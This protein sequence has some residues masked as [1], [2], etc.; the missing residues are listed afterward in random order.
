MDAQQQFP[1]TAIHPIVYSPFRL[2]FK[3][4]SYYLGADNGKGH[5]IHSPF[6]YAF[7]TK[8]LNDRTAYPCYREIEQQRNELRKNNN[9]LDVEDLGAGSTKMK[10][11]QRSIGDIARHSLKPPKYAQLLYRIARHYR[12]DCILELGTSLGITTAYLARGN[13]EATVITCEGASAVAEQAKKLFGNLQL[14]SI[15]C[16]TGDFAETLPDLLNR[17]LRPTMS[18]IDGNH[19]KA[20]TLAYFEM[21]LQHVTPGSFMIFDDIHWSSEMEEAWQIISRHE[22][23]SLSIDL[24]FIGL[25]FFN[26]DIRKQ[27]HYRIRF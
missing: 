4:L 19:R 24:F 20:P 15:E 12:P 22:R 11:R 26:P 25:V 9:L 1:L 27:Q 17:G 2:A 6:V 5:G 8:V 21:L 3:Y 16:I 18:F 14:S 23:V 10:S 13:S 7:I